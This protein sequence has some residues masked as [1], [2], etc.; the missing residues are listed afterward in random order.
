MF[1]FSQ[2]FLKMT[3]PDLSK[4]Q[5]EGREVIAPGKEGRDR[6]TQV[7]TNFLPLGETPGAL[8]R[9]TLD[10]NTDKKHSSSCVS[11]RPLW[12]L[13]S[14]PFEVPWQTGLCLWRRQTE[15]YNASPKHDMPF[16]VR[17][18]IFH[19]APPPPPL[20]PTHPVSRCMFGPQ[21]LREGGGGEGHT[22]KRRD[23]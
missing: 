18:N 12:P 16:P 11:V 17:N 10:L 19:S 22:D 13:F 14:E 21:G 4:K 8:S 9:W 7:S 20:L 15:H 1:G 5:S 6:R 2:Q 3:R 23:W